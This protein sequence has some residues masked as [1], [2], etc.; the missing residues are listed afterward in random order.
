VNKLSIAGQIQ[1]I[2]SHPQV[3]GLT[4]TVDGVMGYSNSDAGGAADV[5]GIG[6]TGAAA[7]LGVSQLNDSVRGTAASAGVSGV[8]EIHTGRGNGLSP[9]RL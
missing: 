5:S 3:I 2:Q 1:T 8:T 7:V 6:A 4:A 9:A